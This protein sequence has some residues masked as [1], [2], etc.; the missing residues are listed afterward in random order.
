MDAAVREYIEAAKPAHRETLRELRGMILA[1]AP[2][3]EEKIAHGFPCYFIGG[4][5]YAACASRAKGVMLYIMGGTL[6]AQYADR[7]GTLADGKS[8][9]QYRACRQLTLEQVRAIVSEMLAKAAA[10]L[11][12]KQ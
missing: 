10:A 2:D 11:T 8:C 12:V 7:L 3:A 4:S 9:I 5:Y 6:V 1:A